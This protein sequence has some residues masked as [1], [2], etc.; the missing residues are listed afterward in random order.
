MCIRD[1][2]LGVPVGPVYTMGDLLKDPH[3]RG[4]LVG[5]KFGEVEVLQPMLPV[6]INGETIK[7]VGASPRL[8]EHTMEI[9]LELGYS[10]DDIAQLAAKGAISLSD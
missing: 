3:I 2:P 1:S 4:L 8:G 5:V 6:M 10:R 7:D 9:L